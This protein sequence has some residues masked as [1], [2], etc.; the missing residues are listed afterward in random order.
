[1]QPD[2]EARVSVLVRCEFVRGKRE[3]RGVVR[4]GRRR[5]AP[6]DRAR[7]VDAIEVRLG[8]ADDVQQVADVR[9]VAQGGCDAGELSVVPPQQESAAVQ[10]GED[11]SPCAVPSQRGDG[12]RRQVLEVLEGGRGK[13]VGRRRAENLDPCG[14]RSVERNA[15]SDVG[16]TRAER[17]MTAAGDADLRANQGIERSRRITLGEIGADALAV[18]GEDEMAAVVFDVV[19]EDVADDAGH[20][21]EAEVD[22]AGGD[23]GDR[24]INGLGRFAVRKQVGGDDKRVD[25]SVPVGGLGEAGGADAVA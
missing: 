7:E 15:A 11:A 20:A 2:G 24:H 8:E 14:I 10:D 9:Q 18:V 12:G 25:V 5:R 23:I 13:G 21:H 1:M 22:L 3:G 17:R 4:R 6:P 19:A 16:A